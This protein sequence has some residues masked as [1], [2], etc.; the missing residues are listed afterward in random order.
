MSSICSG[1]VN[2]CGYTL[3]QTL[4]SITSILGWPFNLSS[5]L[6]TQRLIHPGKYFITRI[7]NL[8]VIR[9]SD[10]TKS[11]KIRSC[12]YEQLIFADCQILMR[13]LPGVKRSGPRLSLSSSHC[14][15]SHSVTGFFFFY[16]KMVNKCKY[17]H[18]NRSCENSPLSSAPINPR[19]TTK[20]AFFLEILA[21]GS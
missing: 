4:W 8:D 9:V 1:K 7:V 19:L 5:V 18:I 6:L 20:L 11:R 10:G 12:I 16:L 15:I 17:F 13:H 2:T 14:H 21:S 3:I